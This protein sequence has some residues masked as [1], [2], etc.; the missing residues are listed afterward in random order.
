MQQF[1]ASCDDSQNVIEVVSDSAREAANGFH[2]LCLAKV[3]LRSLLSSD[4]P[5]DG[6]GSHDGA[7]MFAN[8]RN[9]D[10]NV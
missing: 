10:E 1:R 2:F 8:G 7:V 5:G 6:R 4:V 9:G 3:L